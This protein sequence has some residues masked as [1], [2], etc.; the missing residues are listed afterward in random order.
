MEV[1]TLEVGFKNFANEEEHDP[2]PCVEISNGQF[3]EEQVGKCVSKPEFL[4]GPISPVGVIALAS[5]VLVDV[6]RQIVNGDLK[7]VSSIP[8]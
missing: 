4:N 8:Y 3:S 7:M 5:I 6:F 2:G 1:E